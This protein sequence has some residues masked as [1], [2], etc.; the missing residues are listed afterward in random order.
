MCNALY[1]HA[2]CR[3]DRRD[4]KRRCDIALVDSRP[5]LAGLKA[6]TGSRT[7][8]VLLILFDLSA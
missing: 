2:K 1:D 3:R 4:Q 8:Q 5:N 7:T 6:G